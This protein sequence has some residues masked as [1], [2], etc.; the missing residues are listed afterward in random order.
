MDVSISNINATSWFVSLLLLAE[1]SKV[2]SLS[3]SCKSEVSGSLSEAELQRKLSS[4][5]IMNLSLAYLELHNS[6]STSVTLIVVLVQQ[7]THAVLI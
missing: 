6:I 5:D 4:S 7:N 3:Y 1:G 2:L